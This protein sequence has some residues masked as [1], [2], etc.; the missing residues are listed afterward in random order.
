MALSRRVIAGQVGNHQRNR[1]GPNHISAP[2]QNRKRANVSRYINRFRHGAAAKEV[3]AEDAHE[4]EDQQRPGT[5]PNQPVVEAAQAANRECRPAFSA[6][7][8]PPLLGLSE[9]SLE[10]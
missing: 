4:A 7:C 10:A 8:K 6:A 5:G 1:R 3:E 2:E 9:V